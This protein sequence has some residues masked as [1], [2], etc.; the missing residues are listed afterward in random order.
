LM[1]KMEGPVAAFTRSNVKDLRHAGTKLH[2]VRSFSR[3]S[4]TF[5]GFPQL[6]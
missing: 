3:H 2:F 5:S 6:S 4:A 1:Q